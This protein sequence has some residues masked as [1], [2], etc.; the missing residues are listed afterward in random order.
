MALES[1]NTLFHPADVELSQTTQVLLDKINQVRPTR[2]VLDSLSELRLLAQNSLRYRRQLLGLKQTFSTQNCTV[3]I[4]DDLTSDHLDH[5][6][7]SIAHGVVSLHHSA[8]EYGSDRRRLFIKKLRGTVYVGGYHDYEIRTGGL[9]LFPRIIAAESRGSGSIQT[10]KSL[11]PELDDLLGGGLDEGTSTL[12]MGPSGIGKST[13]ALQYAVTAA[14]SGKKTICFSFDETAAIVKRRLEGRTIPFEKHLENGTI[15]LHQVDPGELSPG[16]FAHRI[17]LAVEKEGAK[18][19]IIDSLNGYLN[20]MPEDRYLILQL[21][22]LLSY[23]NQKGILT[24]LVFTQSGMMGPMR[25]AIDVTY[26]SDTV[27]FFRYFENAGEIKELSLSSKNVR[28]NMSHIFENFNW[29][30]EFPLVPRSL[31]FM[32]F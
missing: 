25:S 17:K 16:E 12:L 19:V 21:H 1:Q 15:S 8:P 31:I 7:E 13:I 11:I 6:V 28:A 5:Q 10:M 24:L 32:E 18:I 2:L 14:E 4:L 29:M 22:E 26:L 23:L 9:I 27:L 20:A 30:R 3:L